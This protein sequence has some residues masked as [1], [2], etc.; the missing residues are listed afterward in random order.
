M[1]LNSLELEWPYYVKFSLL[2]TA[3]SRNYF[4]VLTVVSRNHVISGDVRKRTVIGRI[5]RIRRKKL[6]IFRRRYIVGT[7]TNKANIITQYYLVL[8]RQWRR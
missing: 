1:I 5:F 8:H 7:L 3:L 4:Y 2:R 6:R